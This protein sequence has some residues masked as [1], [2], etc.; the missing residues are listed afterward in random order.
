MNTIEY[1]EICPSEID[2][3][4]PLWEELIRHH[5]DI[6]VNFKN[7]FKT[8]TFEDRKKYLLA[9]SRRLKVLGAEDIYIKKTV[10]YCISS[11]NGEEGKIDSLF[12]KDQYRG[13]NIGQELMNRSLDWL[14]QNEIENIT[15]GVLYENERALQF[16]EKFNFVPM[17]Y[18]LKKRT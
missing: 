3:I 8:R 18:T 16:Y 5:M 2:L 15:I 14:Y 9:D 12:V 10:G 1:R 17:T 13:K 7:S 4:K 6:S 11:I